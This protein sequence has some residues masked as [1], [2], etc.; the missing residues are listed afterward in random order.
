MSICLAI[1]NLHLAYII[2][3][4]ANTAVN[5]HDIVLVITAD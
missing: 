1:V 4:A 2:I 5:I 3:F